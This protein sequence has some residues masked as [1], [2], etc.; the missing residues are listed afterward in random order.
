MRREPRRG[1]IGQEVVG[2][3]GARRVAKRTLSR[4]NDTVARSWDV[5]GKDLNDSGSSFREA[6]R[7]GSCS[8]SEFNAPTAPTPAPIP[9]KMAQFQW[10]QHRLQYLDSVNF[11]TTPA[12]IPDL[13]PIRIS[14]W[15][16]L[17]L[18]AKYSGSGGSDFGSSS[19]SPTRS[20]WAVGRC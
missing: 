7:L 16:Q 5:P 2:K 19:A 20:S 8:D 9:R 6:F 13:A 17:R 14:L 15:P 4:K 3:P 18:R 11:Y 10:L 1:P 12:P